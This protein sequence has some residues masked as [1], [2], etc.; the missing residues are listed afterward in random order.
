[1]EDFVPSTT[2]TESADSNNKNILEQ[3]FGASATKDILMT[4]SYGDE[5]N[6]EVL[7]DIQDLKKDL[8]DEKKD[9]DED[10]FAKN[11]V[12]KD[13]GKL[14]APDSSSDEEL[15]KSCIRIVKWF[16]IACSGWLSSLLLNVTKIEFKLIF[17]SHKNNDK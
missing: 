7:G 10:S 16:P 6:V 1:M 3:D 9:F 11:V 12:D 15:G 5:D 2:T 13:D 14:Y 4:S 8:F 17:I